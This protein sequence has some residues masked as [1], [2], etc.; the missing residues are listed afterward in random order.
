MGK[1]T[2]KDCTPLLNENGVYKRVNVSGT[3]SETLP[4]LELLKKLFEKGKYKAVIEKTFSMDKIVDAHRY[5]DTVRKK[6]NA[7]LIMSE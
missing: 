6:G 1:T 3:A 2:K 4:Q 7:V 5:V